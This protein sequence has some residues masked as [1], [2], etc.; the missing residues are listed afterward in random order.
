MADR[1]DLIVIGAGP[2]G[3]EAAI[4]AAKSGMKTALIERRELGGTCLNRGCIPTKTLLHT[5]E[6]YR[7]VSGAC[8]VGLET[9]NL[10]C[11][12]A[13]LQA[14][15]N[16]VVEQLRGGIAS[17][18]KANK[19]TVVQGSASI[20]DSGRVRVEP[21][22][23]EL[24]TE[25]IL[26]ATGSTPAV[27]PIPGADLPGVVT[28]DELLDCDKLPQSLVII[29]GGVI[30]MEFASVFSA[31]GCRVTVVEA[32]ERIL[33]N[34]DKEIS[35]NLKMIMKKRGVDIHAAAMVQEIAADPEGGLICSYT[36]KDKP[37]QAQGDLVLIATGRRA[38]TEGLFAADASEA[39]K[40]MAMDRGRIQV[41]GCFETSVPGIYAIGDVTGGIQLAHAAT[42]QGRNAVAAMAGK[43]PSI[44]LSVIPGCVYTDPEIG[45]AGITADEAKAAGLEVIS[46]KYVMGANGKSIL[47][48]QERGFIK[49]VA[50]ADTHRILGAQMMCARATDMIS[51]FSAAI[52]NGLTLEDLARVV[53][54]HPTFSEAMGEVVR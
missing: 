41:N 17:L 21:D 20:V 50:A 43:E 18:M 31:L 44:D 3:Y 34:M 54:P 13:Q 7:E 49:V 33:A 48:G 23:T 2:G 24:E 19:V 22:R 47:S 35:Q 39:V 5:S 1:Y 32:L 14:R 16:A 38:C 45:C 9:E 6:L 53:F 4:E 52:V 15:K 11:N 27:P 30:G 42:A 26:I 51:Q 37:A 29:G 46:R 12:M 25:H 36:E 28:S 10:R 8:A 40:S